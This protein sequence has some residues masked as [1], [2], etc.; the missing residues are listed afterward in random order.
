MPYKDLEKQKI[1]KEKWYEDY[2][3]VVASRRKKQLG[4]PHG[5][6]VHRL[7]KIVLFHLAKKLQLDFCFRCKQRIE[8]A[9]E[10]T[11]DHKDPWENV[12]AELFWEIDNIAFSH[13]KCNYSNRR[14]NL[15]SR[16]KFG[17]KGVYKVEDRKKQWRANIT[18]QSRT[19]SRTKKLGSF[20][21]IEEA[22]RAY[23]KEAI[24]LFGKNAITN[25]SLGLL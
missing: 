16:N 9:E 3:K 21:T 2:G 12:D 8:S 11:M 18:S 15:N 24:K 19:K 20:Y 22:A 10:F 17:Y 13:K 6:A 25:K 5:T 23:D 14:N 4:I 1:A 7:R